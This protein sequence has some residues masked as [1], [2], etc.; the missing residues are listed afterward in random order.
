MGPTITIIKTLK[1][2]IFG[3]FT[4]ASW[5]SSDSWKKDPSAFIFSVDLQQ[6]YPVSTVS[7]GYAIFC[8]PSYGPTFGGDNVFDLFVSDHSNG[9]SLS[10][11]GSHP[12]YNLPKYSTGYNGA[13]PRAGGTISISNTS[14]IDG[15][16]YFQ[17]SEVEV[18]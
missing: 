6:K 17:T 10:S 3:A 13:T 14:L 4:A 11:L 2:K 5:D 7:A 15:E 16:K 9:N 18:Y 1:N 8:S 12:P